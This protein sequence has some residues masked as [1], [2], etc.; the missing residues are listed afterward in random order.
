MKAPAFSDLE[1]AAVYRAIDERR[2]VRA[3]F[4]SDPVPDD[5]LLRILEAA[6][7]APSV[8]LSQPWRFIVVRE[9]RTRA[10][11]HAAFERANATAA[12]AYDGDRAETYRALRLAGILDAPVNLCIVCDDDPQRGAGL[13][14]RTMPETARYST[15]CA[16]QNLWLAARAEGLGVGWVSIVEPQDLREIFAIPE[17][18]AIVAYLCVGFVRTFAAEPDLERAAWEKR[19]PLH[20]VLDYE[21][22]TER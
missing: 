5:V 12:L 20:D 13:G 7:R 1:R 11:V 4:V 16:I 3:H 14:R 10:T 8:G 21:V 6:H 9:P 2:D 18:Y 15:V 17:R 19:V 22:F